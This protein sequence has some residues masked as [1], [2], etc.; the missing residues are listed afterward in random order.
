MITFTEEARKRV[1]EFLEAEDE[2][3]AVRIAIRNSSPL[4][5]E[6]DL[7]LI[8]PHERNVADRVFDQGGFE[9]VVDAESAEL[10]EGASVGWVETLQG[11]GFKVESPNL[12]P[13]G[14]TPLTGAVAE[15]VTTVIEER[16]NPSIAAHG[17]HVRLVDLRDNVV[18]L[19]MSGGCQGC[20][21]ASV[22]LKQGIERI[23]R[24]A[25]PEI[26]EIQDVTD[27]AAG[28][29]PYFQPTK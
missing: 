24:D 18:Y 7:S 27:H 4:A 2:Q 20:G 23:L 16:I 1:L 5:P 11:G 13:L 9:L 14:S 12:K 19:Q 6:Y 10:L 22:T 15:R 28:T 26:V 17:G 21:M 3:L 25:V 8:E 29:D